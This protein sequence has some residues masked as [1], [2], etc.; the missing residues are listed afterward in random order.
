MQS[1]VLT[2][3]DPRNAVLSDVIG[4]GGVEPL[5]TRRSLTPSADSE[6][7]T[8]S[9]SGMLAYLREHS[10]IVQ[11]LPKPMGVLPAQEGQLDL[12]HLRSVE[13]PKAVEDLRNDLRG[14]RDPPLGEKPTE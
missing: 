3:P 11:N 1:A 5:Y 10:R 13:A 2:S 6:G 8:S 4:P 14:R 7:P 9:P 12:T